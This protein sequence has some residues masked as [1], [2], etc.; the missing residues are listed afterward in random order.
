MKKKDSWSKSLCLIGYFLVMGI[1]FIFFPWTS[2]W[3]RAISLPLILSMIYANALTKGL[4]SGFGMV[5]ILGALFEVHNAFS[6]K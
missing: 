6:R 1:F 3:P 5:L 2:L 4:V